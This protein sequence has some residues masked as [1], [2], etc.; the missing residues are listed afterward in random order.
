MVNDV[1]GARTVS[2]LKRVSDHK[3]PYVITVASGKGGVGKTLTTVN[4]AVAARRLGH[5]VLILDGD[6]GLANVD[7][8]LGLSARYNVRDV[9]DGN[10]SLKDVIIE[11][12]MG[13]G[14]IPSGSGITSL[15]QL[16][17]VQKTQLFDQIDQLGEGYDLLLIDTGAGIADNVVYFAGCADRLVVVTTPEPHA[18]TD[19]YALIKV[20]AE[21]HRIKNFELLVNQARSGDEG[22]KVADRIAEV[23]MRFLNVQ[24]NFLGHVPYDPQVPKSVMQRRAASEQSTFTVAGQ[25]WNQLARRLINDHSAKPASG[26]QADIWRGLLRDDFKVAAR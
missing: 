2:R 12:P 19:A 11:G 3:S 16:S 25:A 24:V 18:M 20:L 9:L 4:F 22:L 17:Y 21:E 8:L 5:S 6:L 26:T 23:A 1:C 7:V 15:T 13:I 14:V 10:A